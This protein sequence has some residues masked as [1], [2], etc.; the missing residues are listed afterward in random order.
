MRA[1][2]L[3]VSGGSLETGWWGP[4]PDEAPTLVLLHEG[5]GSVALWRDVPCRLAEATGWGV[6]AYSRFGYGNSDTTPLPRPMTYMHHEAH[7]VLPEVLRGAGIRRAVLIGHSDGGSI[8]AIYAGTPV[9]SF[10]GISAR[11]GPGAPR[12]DGIALL[13]LVTIAAHFFVEDLNIASI[14][15]IAASYETGDLRQRLARYHRDVDVAFRGWNDAW[16]DPRFRAFDITG[17][18]PAVQV[19]IL[20]LQGADDPYGT[21]EQLKVFAANVR[22]PIQTRLIPGAKHS[23][24]LEAK[25]ATLAAI[26]DFIADLKRD[27]HT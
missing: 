24:H 26:S 8:A 4:S 22:A 21:D 9:S 19:P 1:G 12:L 25:D 6:F 2:M 3:P 20:A 10:S 7:V 11:E 13:G 15:Q 23:P 14:R 16:L 17:F 5:L 27:F 18:L